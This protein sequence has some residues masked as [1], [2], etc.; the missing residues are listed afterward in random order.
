M[1]E[2][3]RKY[4]NIEKC[5]KNYRKYT[6]D[7]FLDFSEFKKA[8]QIDQF[9]KHKCVDTVNKKDVYV[10]LFKE[11]SI[12]TKTTVQFK[13]LMDKIATS[14]DVIVITKEELNVYIKKTFDAYNKKINIFNYL[15]RVFSIEL[16]KGPLCSTHTI[17][18]NE[19]VRELCSNELMVHPLSLPALSVKDPQNIWIGG[20]LGQ[21]VKIESVSEITGKVIRYRIISPDSGTINNLQKLN[22]NIQNNKNEVDKKTEDSAKNSLQELIDDELEDFDGDQSSDQE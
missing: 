14:S 8:I 17:M 19:E 13:K 7:S 18:S 4:K 10:Y 22:Q 20:V 16:S 21:V 3:Y 11:D 12:Y 2:L 15:H 9:V 1:E 6:T 5:M